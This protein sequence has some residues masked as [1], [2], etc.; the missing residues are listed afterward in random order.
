MGSIP[1]W[2]GILPPGF[3]KRAFIYIMSDPIVGI[4]VEILDINI[5]VR[6]RDCTLFKCKLNRAFSSDTKI[7]RLHSVPHKQHVVKDTLILPTG[8]AVAT[9]VRKGTGAP[10]VWLAHCHMNVHREDGEKE[11]RILGI[12]KSL[13]FSWY[14]WQSSHSSSSINSKLLFSR[15]GLCS[16][17]MELNPSNLTKAGF[18]QT[19][20]TVRC[21]FPEHPICTTQPDSATTTRMH[22]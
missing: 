12:Y 6:Q 8:R 19:I 10:G 1:C 9:R 22:L 2:L 11:R 14:S 5:P 20:P 21:T 17:C 15:C 13:C 3:V 16:W 18:H 7:Q 4:S